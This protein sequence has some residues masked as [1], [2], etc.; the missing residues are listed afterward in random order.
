AFCAG[1]DLTQGDGPAASAGPAG[2]LPTNAADRLDEFGAKKPLIAAIN[3]HALGGG[4]EIALIC[5]LRIGAENA[6]ARLGLPEITLGFFPLAGGPMRLP[7][8]IPQAYANEMLYLGRRLSMEE[9]LQWGV[10]SRLVPQAQLL[11]TAQEMAAQVAGY[12]P[13]AVRAMKELINAQ[14]DMTLAQA[15]RFGGSLRWI[16]GQT[17]D[18]KEGPRAFAEGRQ[19]EFKGE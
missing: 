17:A 8:A 9:A 5:D 7:R 19:P 3:G 14:G 4:F 2:H 11:P 15:N 12:A 1:A 13:I 18:S 6:R 16:V 10:I